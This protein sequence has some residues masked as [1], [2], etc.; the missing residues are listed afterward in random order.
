MPH[1]AGDP[2]LPS[3][4]FTVISRKAR[5]TLFALNGVPTLDAKTRP[6][7][8]HNSPALSLSCACRF[9]C[10]LSASTQRRGSARVRRDLAVFVSPQCRS[11][12]EALRRP[13]GP[14]LRH[15]DQRRDIPRHQII[16]LGMRNGPLQAVTSDL[17]GPS[18]PSYTL[19]FAAWAATGL[20]LLSRGLA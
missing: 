14:T 5:I 8:C 15:L 11:D 19:R 13:P 3:P 6:W 7:S 2:V 16:R 17:Q 1:L 12:G 10:S 4:A 20:A 9:H 18:R